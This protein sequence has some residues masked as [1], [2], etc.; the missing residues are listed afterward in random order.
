M[1]DSQ[2][3]YSNV[4]PGTGYG[5]YGTAGHGYVNSPHSECDDKINGLTAYLAAAQATIAQRDAQ[6]AELT[7]ALE[8]LLAAVEHY[9]DVRANAKDPGRVG[10]IIKMERETNITPRET[11]RP[12]AARMFTAIRATRALLARTPAAPQDSHNP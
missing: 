2:I 12:E 3:P 11:W 10:S 6:V 5:E 7:T 1:S 8:E 4:G 9:D